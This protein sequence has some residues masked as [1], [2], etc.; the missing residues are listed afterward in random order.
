MSPYPFTGLTG[1]STF[2]GTHLSAHYNVQTHECIAPAAD[3]WTNA[4]AAAT[5]DKKRCG[6]LQNYSEHLCSCTVIDSRYSHS[7]FKVVVVV[8][9]SVVAC[10]VDAVVERRRRQRRDSVLTVVIFRVA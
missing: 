8:F 10:T 6:I 9:V 7:V 5:G 4:F 2:G 3:E 1:S